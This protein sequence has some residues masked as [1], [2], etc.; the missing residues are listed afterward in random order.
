VYKLDIF[1]HTAR[2]LKS[3][4]FEVQGL[5][6]EEDIEKLRTHQYDVSIDGDAE[7]AAKER[8]E[9]GNKQG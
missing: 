6:S 5:L 8:L 2:Q 7:K 4:G 9:R 3:G 1:R